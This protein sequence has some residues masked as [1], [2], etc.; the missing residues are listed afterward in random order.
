MPGK[1]AQDKNLKAVGLPVFLF[2]PDTAAKEMQGDFFGLVK[3]I[4]EET[5]FGDKVVA[6]RTKVK[7]DVDKFFTRDRVDPTKKYQH[8]GLQETEKDIEKLTEYLRNVKA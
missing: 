2:T 5:K 4:E 6:E 8:R 7:D 1:N 3:A